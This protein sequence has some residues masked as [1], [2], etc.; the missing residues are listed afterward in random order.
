MDRMKNLYHVLGITNTATEEE[1]KKAYRTLSKKYHPDVNPG[2]SER[3]E[4]FMEISEAY[5]ILQN[6]QKRQEY[7]KM[8]MAEEKNTTVKKE[9]KITDDPSAESSMHFNFSRMDEQFAHFF[10]FQP[11]NGK[12][13][14]KAFNKSGKTKTNPIDMTEMFERYMGI[15]K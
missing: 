11:K 12:V 14:E 2:D 5:A 9:K 8:L 4:R 10:G 1:I 6:S 13:D 15:K 7:D 3:E